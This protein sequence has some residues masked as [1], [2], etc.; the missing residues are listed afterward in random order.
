MKGKRTWGIGSLSICVA[1]MLCML[2]GCAPTGT[3][4]P[5]GTNEPTNQVVNT[6][7]QSFLQGVAEPNTLAFT[8][9]KKA[10]DIATLLQSMGAK[11]YLNWVNMS[12]TMLSEIEVNQDT[13]NRHD[14]FYTDAQYSGVKRMVAVNND[15]LMPIELKDSYRFRNAI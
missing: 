12:E 10:I 6:A 5:T 1:L 3:G 15:W 2:F 7:D 11:S 8:Y 14:G 9:S 13:I 4:S